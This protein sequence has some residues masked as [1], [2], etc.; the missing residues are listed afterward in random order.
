[1]ASGDLGAVVRGVEALYTAGTVAGL[2]DSQLLERFVSRSDDGAEPAFTALVKRHGPMVLRVCRGQLPDVHAAEDAFQA[3]FLILARK[4]RSIQ[5]RGSLASWLYGV[6]RRVARRARI[7]AARRT[8]RERRSLEMAD[9]PTLSHDEP[10]DLLPEVQEEVDHLPEKYRAVIVLCYLEGLTHEEAAGQLRV[11]VGTVKVRLSRGRERLRGRLIR[12][13]LAPALVAATLAA[14][15]HAAVPTPLVDITVKAALKIA[16]VRAAG[17]AGL[18]ASVAALVQGVLRAMFFAK[19]KAIAALT[20]ASLTLLV[21]SLLVVSA[22]SPPVRSG[23]EPAP[24]QHRDGASV[25]KKKVRAGPP[26]DKPGEVT[27]VTL[28]KTLFQRTTAQPGTVQAFDEAEVYPP[29]SGLLSQ[30]T[31]DIG[32]RVKKGQMLA[33]IDS[34]EL[35]ADVQKGKA[36]LARA[37]ARVLRAQSAVRIAEAG[38][39]SDRAKVDSAQTDLK[40]SEATLDYSDLALK[41]MTELVRRNAVE[42]RLVVEAEH[43]LE[44]ARA[45]RS[46]AQAKLVVEKAGIE[47]AKAKLE[48]ALADVEEAKADYELARADSRKTVLLAG[49]TRITAPFDGIITRRNYHK[50]AF[51]RSPKDGGSDLLLSI[52][53]PDVVRVAVRVPDSDVPFL[54]KGDPATIHFD[55]WPGREYPGTIARTAYAEDPSDRTLLAEIDLPNAD[56]RLR[57][58]QFGRVEIQLEPPHP[59]LRIPQTALHTADINGRASCFRV[60]NGRAVLTPIQIGHTGLAEGQVEVLTGLKE[61]DTVV[62]DLR[63]RTIQE[64]QVIQAGPAARVP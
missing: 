17:M 21:S 34:P 31:V 44:V 25:A 52:V 60:V 20:V 3:T 55:A 32:D 24:P 37:K 23:Q 28:Q 6:A 49:L 4:A 47:G 1:M 26:G 53:W 39:T 35:E 48:A 7:E 22:W 54:D 40:S 63:T 61:G 42:Q 12:R 45:A 46:A 19:L 11:P 51:V 8:A 30:L 5:K 43:A 10:P 14:P 9:D 59:V 2:T 57:P 62:A 56:G 13:G 16:M 15:T 64:G 29:V 41:R 50:G 58:G 38:L 33:V 18:S 27:V 36:L